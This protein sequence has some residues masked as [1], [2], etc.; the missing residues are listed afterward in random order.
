[1]LVRIMDGAKGWYALAVKPQHEFQ[2]FA[3]LGRIDEVEG[4]LPSYKDKRIWSD[5][6]K[7]VDAALFPGYV[8]ARFQYPE[9]RVRVLRVTGVRSIVGLGHAACAVPEEEINGI[10]MVANSG[11]RVRPWPFLRTGQRVRVEHGPL[12]GV[13]GIIVEQK[14]D[15]QMVVSVEMLQRSI[16]VV[17]DRSVMSSSA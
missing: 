14:D 7:M 11:F 15:W 3:G 6:T 12:R 8:F 5:R 10:R 1:M 17:L 13:E 9:E 2:V 16:A 4:F